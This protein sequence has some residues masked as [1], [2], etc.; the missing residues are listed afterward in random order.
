[1][2]REPNYFKDNGATSNWVYNKKAKLVSASLLF[3]L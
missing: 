2:L 1:M 3:M